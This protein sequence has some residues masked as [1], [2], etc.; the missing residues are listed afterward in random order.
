MSV[1]MRPGIA[2]ERQPHADNAGSGAALCP[3]RTDPRPGV[4]HPAKVPTVGVPDYETLMRPTLA[5]LANGQP[6]T[7]GQ[8][9]EAVAAVTRIGGHALAEML[10]SGKATV[11]GS[12]VGWALTYMSQ[13]GLATRP[14]TATA[15]MVGSRG[16]GSG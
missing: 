8:I 7:R 1:E 4:A 16:R 9:R 15:L 5:A 6:Q 11:F 3:R 14:N 10:P 12:R 2:Q 13:A